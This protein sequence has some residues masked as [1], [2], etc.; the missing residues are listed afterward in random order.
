MLPLM[1]TLLLAASTRQAAVGG[2]RSCAQPPDGAPSRAPAALDVGT[3]AIAAVGGWPLEGRTLPSSPLEGR[4]PPPLKA[5]TPPAGGRAPPSLEAGRGPPRNRPPCR[6][7][8]AAPP[9]QP[10]FLAA[11]APPPRAPRCW[12]AASSPPA[13]GVPRPPL[14]SCCPEL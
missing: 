7:I 13:P 14:V 2:R 4:A 6:W 5:A 3:H 1:T 10:C 12:S 9:L 11:G 8:S